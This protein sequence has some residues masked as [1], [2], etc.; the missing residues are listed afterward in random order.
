MYQATTSNNVI[1]QIE[2]LVSTE[3]V[4]CGLEDSE[5]NILNVPVFIAMATKRLSVCS[6]RIVVY[7]ILVTSSAI[8]P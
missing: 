5:D 2:M 6:M 3:A 8:Y 7:G 4:G 1:H